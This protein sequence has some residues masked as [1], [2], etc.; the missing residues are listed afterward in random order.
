MREALW[1]EDRG[2]DLLIFAD[3]G[4]FV[5]Y[6]GCQRQFRI[7]RQLRSIPRQ[8]PVLS[9]LRCRDPGESYV[10][11]TARDTVY[12]VPQ[13][14]NCGPERGLSPFHLRK[15]GDCPLLRLF[16]EVILMSC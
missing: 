15:R 6:T 10:P 13:A 9:L 1:R 2:A 8:R 4:D 12:S 5:L 14:A 3:D 16:V 11:E 7:T